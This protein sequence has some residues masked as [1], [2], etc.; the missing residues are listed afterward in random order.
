MSGQMPFNPTQSPPPC[1]PP[2]FNMAPQMQP[3]ADIGPQT[4]VDAPSTS[5]RG[6]CTPIAS[7]EISEGEHDCMLYLNKPFRLVARGRVYHTVAGDSLHNMALPPKHGKVSIEVVQRHEEDSTLPV[8]NEE[9]NLYSLRDA[10][11]TYVSW[12]LSLITLRPKVAP[13]SGKGLGKEISYSKEFIVG[14]SNKGSTGCV[15][16]EI[17]KLAEAQAA[18]CLDMMKLLVRSDQAI[19]IATFQLT[20]E[21]WGKEFCDIVGKE[22]IIEVICRH[23]LSAS[24]INLYIRYLCEAY[25]HGTM[26]NRF[27]F[28]S[29][30]EMDE[31]L[32]PNPHQHITEMLKRHMG[33]D[34][35]IFA[36]YNVGQHW[37]LVAINTGD[38]TI[39][40]MDPLRKQLKIRTHMQNL[41][42]K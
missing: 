24:S 1:M 27:S 17:L 37:V 21:H 25:L 34:H 32:N 28:I 42:N 2:P 16:S 35:L 23:W 26:A 5:H 22:N 38:E 7:V 19:D 11:G 10:I 20:S 13:S 39:Y 41:F 40:Y 18:A 31:A 8:P 29:S 3:M 6:S 36:P 33:E 15:S 9:A 14:P 30:Y 4:P 12:P